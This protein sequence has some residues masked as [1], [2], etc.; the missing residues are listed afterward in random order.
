MSRGA[1]SSYRWLS[2]LRVDSA[3]FGVG[4]G[5]VLFRKT[6]SRGVRKVGRHQRFILRSEKASVGGSD[7]AARLV[8]GELLLK[9]GAIM[10]PRSQR[11]TTV[12]ESAH[13]R[14]GWLAGQIDQNDPLLN[15]VNL[16]FCSLKG[17]GGFSW[18]NVVVSEVPCPVSRGPEFGTGSHATQYSVATAELGALRHRRAISLGDF[19]WNYR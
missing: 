19:S 4:A 2:W 7:L 10:A 6:V 15:D 16:N 9:R 5:A 12:R 14:F 1:K 18:E 13:G 3:P 11:Q 17:N 8:F